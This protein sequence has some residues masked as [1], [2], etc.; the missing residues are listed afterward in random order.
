MEQIVET[1]REKQ[2]YI[3]ANRRIIVKDSNITIEEPDSKV[4]SVSLTPL[5]WTSLVASLSEIDQSLELLENNQYVKY[6]KHL[7]EEYY[8]SV[9]SGFSCV[10]IRKFF[11]LSTKKR[12]YPTKHGVAIYS[13]YWPK[14]KEIIMQ[15]SQE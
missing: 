15:I 9:T 5:L 10:D 1:V 4:K 7:G 8:L 3:S 11:S 6:R 14:A 12:T 2:Y 13:K